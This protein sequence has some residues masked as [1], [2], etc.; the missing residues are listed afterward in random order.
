MAL[1]TKMTTSDFE[2]YE[3]GPY[4]V[5]LKAL[6]LD[7]DTEYQTD[8]RYQSAVFHWDMGDGEEFRERFVKVSLNPRSKFFNR[9]SALLGRPLTEDD[10][11]EWELNEFAIKDADLD[12]YRGKQDT[13]PDSSVIADRYVKTGENRTGI[14]GK[15]DT[16]AINGGNI[17][18]GPA[19]I[20][21][22]EVNDK[23]YNRAGASA[24]SAIPVKKA[25]RKKPAGAP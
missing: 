22:L 12:E 19:C 4:E 3:A 11:V 9:V 18:A 23:G 16:L 14:Q 15:V 2:A 1:P 13:D 5:T 17:I 20:L 10:D 8:L 25:A 21:T 6:E 24:A 7:T